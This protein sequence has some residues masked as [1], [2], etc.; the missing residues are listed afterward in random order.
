VIRRRRLGAWE[1]W[2]I[3]HHLQL[4]RDDIR[5][6][7]SQERHHFPKDQTL[8]ES[9]GVL[10]RFEPAAAWLLP[11]YSVDSSDDRVPVPGETAATH[12]VGEP[13]FVAETD[14]GVQLREHIVEAVNGHRITSS[15]AGLSAAGRYGAL[16]LRCT[17]LTHHPLRSPS[18][19]QVVNLRSCWRAM[20][21]V[22][23]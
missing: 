15:R 4:R 8:N 18:R 1:R 9:E 10:L 2:A 16:Y 12:L 14:G 11:L 13:E 7:R 22:T 19:M 3:Q 20:T 5:R 17:G 6:T 21:Q 23:W